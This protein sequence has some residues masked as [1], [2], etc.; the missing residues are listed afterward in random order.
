VEHRE[1][2]AERQLYALQATLCQTLADPTRLE[3]LHL[4]SSGPKPV[5][6][7]VEATGQRQANI[8]QHLALMRQRGIVHATRSGTEA[9]YA[10]TD[11]RVLEACRLMRELLLDQLAARGAL[12]G[13]HV[14]REEA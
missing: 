12:A 11:M 8:S 4:L 10:L 13:L 5:K 1:R 14:A 9:H 2:E 7:L 3:L 6:A